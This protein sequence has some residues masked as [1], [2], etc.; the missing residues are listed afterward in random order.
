[1]DGFKIPG[2]FE[3]DENN[4][5]ILIGPNEWLDPTIEASM[6]PTEDFFPDHDDF[7]DGFTL[8]I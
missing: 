7:P 5:C 1:M 4:D 6:F 2:P 3:D 8:G